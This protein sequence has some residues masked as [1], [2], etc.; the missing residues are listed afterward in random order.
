MGH[1]IE[2]VL[3]QARSELVGTKVRVHVPVRAT[4]FVTM[5]MTAGTVVYQVLVCEPYRVRGAL[6]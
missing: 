4:N 6:V 2:H 1:K 3:E 5:S